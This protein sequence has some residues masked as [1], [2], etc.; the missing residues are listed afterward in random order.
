LTD[1]GAIGRLPRVVDSDDYARFC[2]GT[3]GDPYPLLSWLREHDPVHRS[4]TL[5]AWVLTRY[6]HVR[7]G[8]LDR[9][10]A[11]DRIAANLAPLPAALRETAAPLAEHISNWLGFTDPPKHTRLRALLRETFTPGLPDAMA[12]RIRAIAD[13]LLGELLEQSEPDLIAGYAL[14]LPALVICDILGL[15]PEHTR[16]FGE[17]SDDM[18]A[19]TG[20]IGPSLAH[21]VPDALASYRALDGFIAEQ[22]DA[23]SGCPATDLLGDLAAAEAA[24]NLNRT[25]LTGLAVFTLVACHETTASLLGTAI[26]TLLADPELARTLRDR[27]ERWGAM[28]EEMLRLES[29]I[30]LSPRVAAEELEIGGRTIRRGDSVVLHLGAA[31]RDPRQFPSPDTI[32]LDAATTR[33]LAFAWGPHFCLGAPLA[34]A[35]ATIALPLLLERAPDLELAEPAPRW[36]SNMSIRGLTSLPARRSPSDVTA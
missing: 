29:P 23:R 31:N 34:R 2:D 24:G 5:G 35:E 19:V 18:A 26:R 20:H 6:E 3:L 17:W 30:Q 15:A 16:R 9:R 33:H 7:A 22:V 28:T 12:E 1:L 10:L 4:E 32:D 27:P 21:I 13:Q 25:E 11:N 8:L 36:R 14:P